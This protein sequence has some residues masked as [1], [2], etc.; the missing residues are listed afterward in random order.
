MKA[1]GFV[2][3]VVG[4]LPRLPTNTVVLGFDELFVTPVAARIPKLFAL[5]SEIV[6]GAAA[7]IEVPG[8]MMK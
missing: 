8:T 3:V 2:I 5:P 1:W 4:E 6:G 7:L